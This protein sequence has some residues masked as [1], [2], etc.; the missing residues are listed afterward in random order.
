N[1][2]YDIFPVTPKHLPR[3][4]PRLCADAK[5]IEAAAH[6]GYVTAIS[7]NDVETLLGGSDSV[8]TDRPQS[9]AISAA[10]A[11][12][13]STAHLG[14]Y[15]P[16]GPQFI[17]RGIMSLERRALLKFLAASPVLAALAPWQQ[18]LAEERLAASAAEAL[19]VFDLE[20][21]AQTLVPPAHWG[22]LQS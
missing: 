22:Y 1:N 14:R 4:R 8:S 16:G 6:E 2:L 18:A 13:P 21:V 7:S 10:L 19:D 3:F 20:A 9:G 5:S 17:G 11:R 15:T 12:D